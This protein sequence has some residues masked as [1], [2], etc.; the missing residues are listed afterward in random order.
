MKPRIH[1]SSLATNLA[2]LHHS[3][4]C[5]CQPSFA[6]LNR[7]AASP[8]SSPPCLSP[9]PRTNPLPRMLS[10]PQDVSDFRQVPD[11]Q[12]RGLCICTLTASARSYMSARSLHLHAHTCLYAHCICTLIHVCTLTHL[13]SHTLLLHTVFTN[14]RTHVSVNKTVADPSALQASAPPLPCEL[15]SLS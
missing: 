10:G 4:L 9:P 13:H 12:A 7:I 5:G 14:P 2:V 15:E 8:P 11:N 6:S 3:Q 1:P